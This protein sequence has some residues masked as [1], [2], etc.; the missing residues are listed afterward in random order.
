MTAAVGM[1]RRG[2]IQKQGVVEGWG[3]DDQTRTPRT[4][5]FLTWVVMIRIMGS[6]SRK[7]VRKTAV[8][9]WSLCISDAQETAGQTARGSR[10]W[11][12]E[13]KREAWAGDGTQESQ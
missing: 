11:G 12:S 2:Q 5:I 3:E 1:E 13:L 4:P 9:V 6:P 8:P 10:L 7:Q